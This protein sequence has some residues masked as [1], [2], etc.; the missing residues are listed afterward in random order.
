[1]SS[2]PRLRD[3]QPVVFIDRK[4]RAHYDHLQAGGRTNMRGDYIPH[5]PAIGA[6]EGCRIRSNK[7]RYYYVFPATLAQHSLN[8]QRHATIVYPKDVAAIL[9]WA[10]VGPGHRVIEGGFGSGALSMALLRAIG[11]EGHLTTYELREESINRAQKNVRA[12]LG[13]V[14]H[15]TVIHGDI[16]E[17]IEATGVDRVILDVPEPWMVVPHA[18]AALRPGGIFASY[19]P[20]AIQMQKVVL[21]MEGGGWLTSIECME[22]L[23]RRWHVTAES[24]RPK[25]SMVG[26]TGFLVFG[27]KIAV[28]KLRHGGPSTR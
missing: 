25:Q 22:L 8:M 21:K 18:E 4:Q 2:D 7:G 1:M 10:D 3:G 27:R 19:V 12:H 14:D 20:T 13:E 24:V 23:E 6:E 11:P 26:H 9:S 16:Y 15:H 5:D 28:R 17:G